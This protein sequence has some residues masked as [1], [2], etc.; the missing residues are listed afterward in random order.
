MSYPFPEFDDIKP[1]YGLCSVCKEE[2]PSVVYNICD[3][4]WD[5][6]SLSE[7]DKSFWM[8]PK[9]VDAS[10]Y[11]QTRPGISEACTL[12]GCKFRYGETVECDSDLCEDC[13][14]IPLCSD[15]ERF[16]YESHP[17]GLNRL[18]PD[19]FSV[20]SNLY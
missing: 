12:C 2:N 9:I 4:C 7:P 1:M 5:E 6:I 15:C 16:Q 19:C 13:R 17:D 10:T 18:C 14:R 3:E 20:R 11:L 8:Y